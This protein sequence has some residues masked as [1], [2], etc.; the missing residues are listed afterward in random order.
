MSRLWLGGNVERPSDFDGVV[1]IELDD[2]RG[3]N[4]KLGRE[5]DAVGFEIDWNKVMLM[6]QLVPRSMLGGGDQLFRNL[7]II[8]ATVSGRSSGARRRD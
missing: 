3:W 4:Q 6:N 2:A 8:P 7:A 1:Y 5:L